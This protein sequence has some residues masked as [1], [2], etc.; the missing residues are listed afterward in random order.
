[1]TLSEFLARRRVAL[2][3]IAAI[4]TLILARPTWTMWRIG[5]LVAAAGEGVRI[6]AAGHLEKSREVTR[7][8]PYRWMRHPLYAGSAIMALVHLVTES[9][10]GVDVIEAAISSCDRLAVRIPCVNVEG[11]VQQ[12]A[13]GIVA[14]S[15]QTV[16]IRA[17]VVAGRPRN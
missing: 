6:W 3:F 12:V 7:S 5:L 9:I 1:M 4:A 14:G 2:G 17:G 10:V 15:G 16:T 11:V 8:G 13:I